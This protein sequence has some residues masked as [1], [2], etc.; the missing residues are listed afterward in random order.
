MFHI[1]LVEPEIPQN[2]GNISRTCSVTGTALHL[3]HPFGFTIDDAKLKRAGLDYWHSLALYEHANFEDAERAILPAFFPHNHI[4]LLSTH[5]ERCYTEAAFHDGDA[6][7]FGK[8]TAGLPAGLLARYDA[9]VLRIPMQLGQ[10]SLN[11]SNS[12][13]IVLFASLVMSAVIFLIDL[14]F[15][16]IMLLIYGSFI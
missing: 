2:T 6:F 14:A 9:Q 3:V 1:V 7:V 5:A 11:L 15:E 4:W 13:A 8:E 10:R 12:A 16:K